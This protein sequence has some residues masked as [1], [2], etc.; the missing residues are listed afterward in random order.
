MHVTF[1]KNNICA[2]EK[3]LNTFEEEHFGRKKKRKKKKE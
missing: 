3:H 1:L 2:E